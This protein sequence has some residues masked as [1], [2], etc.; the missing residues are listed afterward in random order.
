MG[1]GAL[2]EEREGGRA[3]RKERYRGVR[4]I[5]SRHRVV[6]NFSRGR[7]GAVICLGAVNLSGRERLE[8]FGR[9][10]FFGKGMP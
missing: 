7:R 9:L 6:V 2:G 4:T 10:E 1:R 8:I 5:K 3:R